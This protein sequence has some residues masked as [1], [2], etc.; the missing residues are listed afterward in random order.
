MLPC[1]Y[2]STITQ[3]VQKITPRNIKEGMIGSLGSVVDEVLVFS[4][5]VS[6][7]VFIS[8]FFAFEVT[9]SGVV[10]IFIF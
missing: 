2:P 6:F 3:K 9:D 4:E 7:D 10:S 1:M 5:S 8:V